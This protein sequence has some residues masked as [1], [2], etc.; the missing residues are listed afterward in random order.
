MANLIF[1]V[2]MCLAL[3]TSGAVMYHLWRTRPAPRVHSGLA[4]G[5]IPQT[6]RRRAPMA[7]RRA[8]A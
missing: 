6:L 8:A 2:A 5:Q 3:P 4:V 7:V 1:V